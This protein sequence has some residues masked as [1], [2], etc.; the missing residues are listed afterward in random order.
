M[1][2]IILAYFAGVI[3]VPSIVGGVLLYWHLDDKRAERRR[4]ELMARVDEWSCVPK[5]F[6][7]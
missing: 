5:E 7:N 2:W 1:I 4:N 3:T 6:R